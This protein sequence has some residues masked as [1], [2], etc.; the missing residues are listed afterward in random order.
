MMMPGM[1]G[2]ELAR[3]I[4]STDGLDAMPL[5]M[6]TSLDGTGEVELSKKTGI[7]V[8][9]IKPVRQ[10][11]LLNALASVMGGRVADAPDYADAGTTQLGGMSVLLAE[12]HAVNQDVGKAMLEYLGCS[13][14]VAG[15]GKVRPGSPFPKV[16]RCDSHGLPNA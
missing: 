11:Q 4:K 7:A 14:E 9:L 1:D 16:I 13:A 12:D 2:I 8:H 5:I 3:T 6:L 10:S 15:N